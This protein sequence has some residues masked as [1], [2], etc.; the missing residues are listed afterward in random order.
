MLSFIFLI[1][2]AI[3]AGVVF[4]LARPAGVI[5]INKDTRSKIGRYFSVPAWAPVLSVKELPCV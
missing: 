2:P 4:T 3:L 5:A 1:L